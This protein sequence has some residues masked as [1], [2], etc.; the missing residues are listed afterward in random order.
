[1]IKMKVASESV[2][3]LHPK[4]GPMNL[5]FFPI[6]LYHVESQSEILAVPMWILSALIRLY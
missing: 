3:F 4:I 6:K 5:M 1:M 2:D